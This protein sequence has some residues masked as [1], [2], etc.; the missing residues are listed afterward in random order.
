M[1]GQSGVALSGIYSTLRCAEIGYELHRAYWS[2]GFT[3]EAL[4][5]ILTY[6]FTN[7][8]HRTSLPLAFNEPSVKLLIKLGFKWEGT[9]PGACFLPQTI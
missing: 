2:K 6:G 9:I 3:S 7:M 4:P 1:T 8:D 5:V